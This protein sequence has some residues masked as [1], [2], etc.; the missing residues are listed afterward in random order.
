MNE[1][2]KNRDKGLKYHVS[3]SSLAFFGQP[4][5]SFELIN[6]YGTYEI[7][8]TADTENLFPMIAQGLPKQWENV[9]IDK[10]GIEKE[11]RE[12]GNAL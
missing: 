5:D 11:N 12:Q 8:R 4:E 2:E 1:T 6:C 7:Q 3:P 10:P 9:A